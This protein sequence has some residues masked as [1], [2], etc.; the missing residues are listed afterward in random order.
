MAMTEISMS[1]HFSILRNYLNGSHGF[2]L[3]EALVNSRSSFQDQR[4]LWR[5][6]IRR[7]RGEGRQPRIQPFRVLNDSPAARATSTFKSSNT[8]VRWQVFCFRSIS[9]SLSSSSVL[10]L[11]TLSNASFS[12]IECLQASFA[13]PIS[14]M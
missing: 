4:N 7:E 9:R 1:I 5:S 11:L 3:C 8:R 10:N 6:R 2:P 13:F 14:L 12:L